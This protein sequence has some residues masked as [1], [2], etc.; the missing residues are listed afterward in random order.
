V[1]SLAGGGH[2]QAAQKLRDEEGPFG[3][4]DSHNYTYRT[5]VGGTWLRWPVSLM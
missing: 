4:F 1:D 5:G 3:H 2:A